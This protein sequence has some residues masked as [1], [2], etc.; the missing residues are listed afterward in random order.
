MFSPHIVQGNEP[1]VLEL[2]EFDVF[3]Q[4]HLNFLWRSDTIQDM[5]ITMTCCGRFRADATSY[6][7]SK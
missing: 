6:R 1:D 7:R 5:M 2:I 3:L 4:C